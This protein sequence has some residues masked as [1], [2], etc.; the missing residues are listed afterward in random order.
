MTDKGDSKLVMANKDAK[1][2]AVALY[3]QAPSYPLAMAE[4]EILKERALRKY[5]NKRIE[6]YADID[7]TW[8]VDDWLKH[9]TAEDRKRLFE[10]IADIQKLEKGATSD[11]NTE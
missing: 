11:G 10:I 8:E 7:P 1:G 5:S 9:Y 3:T 6:G 4:L 2:K